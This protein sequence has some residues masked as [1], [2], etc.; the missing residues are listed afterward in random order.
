MNI[1][2]TVPSPSE[3]SGDT[4]PRCGWVMINDIFYYDFAQELFSLMI[5][6]AWTS[7]FSRNY[8]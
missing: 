2:S 5:S 7:S 1:N 8:D 3:V 4:M 6:M